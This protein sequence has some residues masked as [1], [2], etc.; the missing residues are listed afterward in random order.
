MS[1]GL[2][3]V[4]QVLTLNHFRTW[5]TMCITLEA[6]LT[7][8]FVS[9]NARL[10]QH[11]SFIHQYFF[12]F[13]TGYLSQDKPK[14]IKAEIRKAGI[15]QLCPYVAYKPFFHRATYGERS[16]LKQILRHRQDWS[17]TYRS[18]KLEKREK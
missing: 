16:F 15:K 18:Q 4:C 14:N 8:C 12:V 6:L 2:L 1:A 7:Y 5:D 13:V 3:P 10:L 11:C 9:L 17:K